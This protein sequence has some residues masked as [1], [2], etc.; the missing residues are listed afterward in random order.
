[1]KLHNASNTT[2]SNHSNRLINLSGQFQTKKNNNKKKKL[3][4]YL[5]QALLLRFQHKV[6]ESK[7][8]Y[9]TV[10]NVDLFEQL[11]KIWVYGQCL[12]I[13]VNNELQNVIHTKTFDHYFN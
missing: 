5:L 2:M 13:W 8:C 9:P 11:L 4:L 12:W 3:N 7:R 10:R 1:M 6:L